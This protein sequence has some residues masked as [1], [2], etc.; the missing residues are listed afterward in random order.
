[1]FQGPDE[2]HSTFVRFFDLIIFFLQISAWIMSD[3][4]AW[5]TSEHLCSL[6]LFVSNFCPQI[7][8]SVGRIWMLHFYRNQS[9]IFGFIAIK[10][11][12]ALADCQNG[13]SLCFWSQ[14]SPFTFHTDQ[15]KITDLFICVK[16]TRLFTSYLFFCSNVNQMIKWH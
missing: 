9:F 1:M 2:I 8:I 6:N 4:K 3:L 5:N 14:I 12:W 11:P 10:R 7:N 15:L 16:I 13:I